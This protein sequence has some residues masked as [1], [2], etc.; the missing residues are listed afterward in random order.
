MDRSRVVLA[1]DN[2]SSFI[3]YGT[4]AAA[5]IPNVS[6]FFVREVPQLGLPL[7]YDMGFEW[8]DNVT[9]VIKGLCGLHKQNNTVLR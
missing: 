5:H 1:C 2:P 3:D 9:E 4:N 8:L 7:R 6:P